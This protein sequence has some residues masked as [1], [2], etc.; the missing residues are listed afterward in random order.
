MK[1][2]RKHSLLYG[3]VA[4]LA[5][6]LL[7]VI[8][9]ELFARFYLGLGDPPL[10]VADEQVEYRF[11]PGEYQRFGNRIFYNDYSMRADPVTPH[12]QDPREL[13]ILVMGDSVVNGG[14]LTD[15]E[16]L[17]S[18]IL[19]HRLQKALDRP[20][21]VGHISAGSWGPDNLLAYVNKYGWFDAD[22]ALLV[23]SSHD[24]GDIRTFEPIVG[25]SPAFP[26]HAPWL[27]IQE[28][29]TRYLP[30]YLPDFGSDSQPTD[31]DDPMRDTQQTATD[32]QRAENRRLGMTA[33][34]DLLES[35]KAEHVD[36][37]I[38]QHPTQTELAEG[39]Q[40]GAM[41][42]HD[43]S[44]QQ[45]IKPQMLEP[46]WRQA[47]ANGQRVYRDDIHINPTGQ[48]VLADLFETAV[49]IWLAEPQPASD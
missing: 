37:V 39:M 47:Q 16:Q 13:R 41:L 1:R 15:H 21:W 6:L 33:L 14:S 27:A 8:A 31:A 49:M 9:M 42:I 43:V 38:F 11:K 18:T 24:A 2:H 23:L 4:L 35:A 34:R 7:G 26:D 19:Q 40:P 28:G 12:K 17:A 46:V 22:L 3:L 10:N 30:R 20:V 45:D 36:M 25:I 5:I 29:I 44:E 48:A 32:D